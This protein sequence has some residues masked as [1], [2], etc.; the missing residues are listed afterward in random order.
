MANDTYQHKMNSA[1]DHE[2]TEEELAELHAQLT[3]KHDTAAEWEQLRKTDE[4]LRTTP[5]VAP[6]AAFAKRVM[7][8]LATLPLPG[9]ARRDL[10]VGLALGLMAAAILAIPAL[11]VVFLVVL[12]LVTDPG[13]FSTLLQTS[14]DVMTY[15]VGLVADI[16]DQVR[17]WVTGSPALAI[18][19][20]LVIPL[21]ALWGWVLWIILGGRGLALRRIRS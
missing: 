20:V 3:A 12:G 8:A 19:L 13:T 7:E 16:A 10:S 9:F 1:L 15:G 14:I 2:L 17:Q 6:S 21:S 4:L 18:L 5:M 11:I